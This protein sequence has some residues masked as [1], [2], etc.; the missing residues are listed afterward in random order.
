[1]DHEGVCKG[2]ALG[3]NVKKSF[4]SSESRSKEILDLV[5]SDVC[6]PI[7]MKSLG[8]SLY[9][10]TFIDD[11]LRKTWFYSMKTKDEVFNNF[12]QFKTKVENLTGNK[13]K[14]PRDNGREYTSK[15]LLPSVKKMGLRGS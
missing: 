4:P 3:K 14:I 13:I 9:Y 2:C 11:F 8:G 15:E 5:H 1:M 12:Q 7:S 10:I 6:G